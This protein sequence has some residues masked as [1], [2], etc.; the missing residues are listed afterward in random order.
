MKVHR[1]KHPDLMFNN[2]LLEY[3][4]NKY[5]DL[6]GQFEVYYFTY[7]PVWESEVF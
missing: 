1:L 3:T 2:L 7:R 5:C 6:I 4:C